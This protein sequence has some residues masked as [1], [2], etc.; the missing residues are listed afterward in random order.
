LN[1]TKIFQT[2]RKKNK[3]LTPSTEGFE[4]NVNA[5]VPGFYR[6]SGRGGHLQLTAFFKLIVLSAGECF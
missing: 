1:D 6:K 4:F 5:P 3:P 2:D